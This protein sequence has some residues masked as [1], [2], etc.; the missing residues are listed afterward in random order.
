M[1]RQAAATLAL[2]LALGAP[3]SA[4]VIDT[5][6]GRVAITPVAT[7]LTEP[8]GIA[9]LPDGRAL[10]TER[11][12]RLLLL[13][14]RTSRG[15]GGRAGGRG[16]RAGRASRRDGPARLRAK[17]RRVPQLL[18]ATGP[19]RRDG[20]CRGA[21][22]GGRRASGRCARH[23]RDDRWQFG[24]AAFR[25]PHRRGDGRHDLPHDRRPRRRHAGAG[26]VAPQR[27]GHPHQ[28]RRQRARRQPLRGRRRR[29][30][31]D[32]ELRPPQPAGRLARPLGRPLGPRAWGPRR[33]RGEPHPARREL[34]LA[35]DLLRAA[36]FGRPDR[37]GD[38]E[39]RDGTARLL[40]GPLHRAVGDAV[41][42]GRA[43]A[44]VARRHLRRLAQLGPRDPARRRQRGRGRALGDARDDARARHPSRRRTGRSGSC[45]WARGRSSGWRRTSAQLAR[46]CLESFRPWPW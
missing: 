3:L 8:W 14:E 29:A 24:R 43:L 7:G 45:R 40:L 13:G 2:T 15:R 46:K 10:V 32:L 38:R 42:L 31:R 11:D 27:L 23:L 5:S 41:L 44:R 35:R 9:F 28:P 26:P 39:G 6:A 1:L 17:P 4:E 19:G 25:Q 30:T 12:G 36:V 18:E 37:R 20:A 22:F 34:R 21:A 33:G 16:R